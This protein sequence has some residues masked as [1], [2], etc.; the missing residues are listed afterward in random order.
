MH[1]N[2]MA[3]DLIATDIVRFLTLEIRNVIIF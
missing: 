3:T 2:H 1:I